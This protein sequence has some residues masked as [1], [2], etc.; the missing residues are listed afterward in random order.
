M[1]AETLKSVDLRHTGVKIVEGWG[2][3]YSVNS[4]VGRVLVGGLGKRT[5]GAIKIFTI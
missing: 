5:E 2:G 4:D 3:G 1:K